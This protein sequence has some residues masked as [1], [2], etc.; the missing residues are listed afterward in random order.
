MRP[1][2]SIWFLLPLMFTNGVLPASSQTLPAFPGAEG[3]GS[4]A[5]GGRG[6]DV[7]YV[8]NRNASGAGSFAYGI[9]NAPAAGR[10][11]VFAVSGH[12]RLSSGSGGGLTI[13]KNKITVAGQTAPGDGI[14]FWN[15][16]MNITGNDTVIRNIRWRYGKQA[17][18]GDSVDIANSQRIILDH[19]DVMFSTDENLSSFGT[20]PEFFTFQWSVNAW[21]LNGHSCGGLWDINHATAHHTLWANNHTRN[22]KCISPSVFDWVNNV[23]FGWDIGFNLAAST[24]PIARVNIRGSY[25]V[26]G[27]NTSSAVYGGGTNTLGDNI[28]KLHMADSALDGTAN[29]LLDV[30]RTNY[31]MV[32]SSTY[33]QASTAW[34][35]TLDGVTGGPIIGTPVSL[36]P[37][38]T[39]YKKSSPRPVPSA[40]KSAPARCEMK[41]PSSAWTAPPPCSAASFPILS[42][43]TS[44]PAP[45]SPTSSP[46]PP[47]STPTSTACLTVGRTPSATTRPSPTTTPSSPPH[48]PQ[49]PFSHPAHPPVTPALRNTSTSKPSRTVPSRKTQPF[50]PPSSTSI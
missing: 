46:P 3:F 12:I 16:T 13:N 29:G 7:Y 6:G 31:S 19:C 27:G 43:S 47:R 49:P 24:D 36:D 8:T 33:D 20:P 5:T 42:N 48:K 21:G 37:R 45:P 38:L 40:W 44:P 26:H 1:I 32:S 2:R 30:S 22:P 35:Q 14:C 25:F 50:R 10:T 41:S 23:T 17:A 4:I 28:F 11:I 15:N 18:G 39:A 9:Q 34:P